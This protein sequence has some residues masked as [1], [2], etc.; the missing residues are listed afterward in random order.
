MP[1]HKVE[2][3]IAYYDQFREKILVPYFSVE[4]MYPE[5]ICTLTVSKLA[6]ILITSQLAP[7][8]IHIAID[9]CVKMDTLTTATFEKL[10]AAIVGNVNRFSAFIHDFCD[11]KRDNDA[12][13]RYIEIGKELGVDTTIFLRFVIISRLCYK[14]YYS[15]KQ[16]FQKLMIY[17]AYDDIPVYV[18]LQNITVKIANP[19]PEW[20]LY[21]VNEHIMEQ[22]AHQLDLHYLTNSSKKM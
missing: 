10:N 17:K 14:S 7:V 22:E 13:F 20:F 1:I 6:D 18:Y 3:I 4:E 2:S 12:Y 5:F 15:D 19:S 11:M 21:G 9:I 8:D 16:L